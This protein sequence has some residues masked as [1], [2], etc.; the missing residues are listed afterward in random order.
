MTI[1]WER[2]TRSTGKQ[3]L[4]VKVSNCARLHHSE[5]LS[6]NTP[7][8][9]HVD[10]RAVVFFKKNQF[11]RSVPSCD[12]VTSQLALHVL[13]ELFCFFK[14]IQNFFA[15]WVCLV[16][17]IQD[18]LFFSQWVWWWVIILYWCWLS[19]LDFRTWYLLV[20]NLI[21][22]PLVFLIKFLLEP[23]REFKTLGLN[24]L[25]WSRE[26]KI[27]NLN[28]T[29]F[30]DQNIG[31]LKI[32]VNNICSVNILETTKQ[33]VNHCFDVLWLEEDGWLDHFLKITLW[34]LKNYIDCAKILWICGW[35]HVEKSD[36][37]G[38][39]KWL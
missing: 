25:K 17:F 29:I 12:Y 5:Q 19:T 26:S 13:P 33:V 37:S 7:N 27:S 32:S 20:K 3:W 28:T 14:L 22:V 39:F 24:A 9:P 6:K 38:T 18:F 10:C 34:K 1:W 35:N 16:L 23:T 36:H 2:E 30:I 31:G 15:L 8:W 11:G 21:R 4:S